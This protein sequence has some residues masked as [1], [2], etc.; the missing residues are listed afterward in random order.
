MRQPILFLAANPSRTSRLA[1]DEECDAIE[2]E[3]RWTS[4]RD[5]FEFRSKWALTV[6]DMMRQLDDLRPSV[7]HFSG[8]DSGPFGS[9][10]ATLRRM[11]AVAPPIPAASI[12]RPATTRSW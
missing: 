10:A 3:L 4:H 11:T 5:D 12:S 2:R 6:D 9:A 1:L 8:H 7:V